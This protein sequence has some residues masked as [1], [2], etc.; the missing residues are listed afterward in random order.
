M[1]S[2]GPPEVPVD[3]LELLEVVVAELE[4]LVELPVDAALVS[5]ELAEALE[6]LDVGAPPLPPPAPLVVPALAPPAPPVPL[7]LLGAPALP[8]PP[9]VLVDVATPPPELLVDVATP[10]PPPAELVVEVLAPP[11]PSP[12]ALAD[13]A[14]PPDDELLPQPDS[15]SAATNE[16]REMLRASFMEHFLRG[17]EILAT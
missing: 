11:E 2:S 17:F 10:G 1:Q 3:A 14:L 4:L 12:P 6:L 15:A 7:E 13:D 8:P 5:P 9:E 16:E